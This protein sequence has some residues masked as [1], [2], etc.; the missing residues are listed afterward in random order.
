MAEVRQIY[1]EAGWRA[2][3]QDDA[4]LERAF[5]R[6]LYYTGAFDGGRL[7]GFVRCVG[8]G[9]HILYV[10][11]LIVCEAYRGRGVGTK[12][13]SLAMEK[14]AHERMVTLMTDAQDERA[15]AF[16]RKMGLKAY[17]AG[18]LVGYFR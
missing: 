4:A 14:F 1:R 6:S 8:D 3:L 13:L 7:I 5:A 12:L 15:N 17:E 2:Y 10:Q 16:Y 11:D 18:G 9:E